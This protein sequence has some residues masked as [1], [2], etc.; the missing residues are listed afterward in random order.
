MES[1][2]FIVELVY[3][4]L[5]PEQTKAHVDMMKGMVSDQSYASAIRSVKSLSSFNALSGEDGNDSGWDFT[6]ES[7]IRDYLEEVKPST[8]N[9]FRMKSCFFSHRLDGLRHGTIPCGRKS[10][11]SVTIV[12]TATING[13]MS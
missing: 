4:M 11:G 2:D 8:M 1:L 12:S 5:I 13:Q 7:G 9:S 10:N 3:D 6:C